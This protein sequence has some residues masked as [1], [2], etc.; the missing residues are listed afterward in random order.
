MHLDVD[1]LLKLHYKCVLQVVSE[2][3]LPFQSLSAVITLP[4]TGF[5]LGEELTVRGVVSNP[6]SSSRKVKVGVCIIRVSFITINQ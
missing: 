3:N 1:L 5:Y 6:T 2:N 4:K